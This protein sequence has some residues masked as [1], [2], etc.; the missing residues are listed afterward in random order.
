MESTD[1]IAATGQKLLVIDDEATIRAMLTAYLREQSYTVFTAETGHDGLAMFA[2]ETPALVLVD[3]RLPD[4]DG[5]EVMARIR[6][7]AP[8]TPVIV[9]SASSAIDDAIEALRLGAWEFLSKPI[10]ELSVLEHA[11]SRALERAYLL[12]ENRAYQENLEEL[13]SQRTRELEQATEQLAQHRDHLEELV[14]AR[15]QE[16][17]DSERRFRTL[18]EAA[19]EGVIIHD[20]GT[21]IW[22]NDLACEKSGYSREELL[23]GQA[24]DLLIAPESRQFVGQQ[25]AGD[26]RKPYE[27]MA[28]RKDETVF[29]VEVHSRPMVYQG[30]TVRI[31]AINDI[32]ERKAAERALRESERR[33]DAIINNATAVIC[34]KDITGRYQLV[35]QRFCELFDTTPEEAVG[36]TDHDFFPAQA[37]YAFQMND[38]KVLAKK[39]AIQFQES[40]PGAG[41]VQVYLSIKFPLCDQQGQTYGVCSI[42]SDITE[43]KRT[44][45]MMRTAKQKAEKSARQ[46]DSYAQELEWRNF[47]LQQAQKAAE[48]ASTAKSEFL[49]NMS[50]EIRTPMNGIMGMTA[51]LE[52]TELTPDQRHY[53]ETISESSDTLMEIINNILDFSRIEAG[54]ME[55]NITSFDLRSL[56]EDLGDIM[57]SRAHDQGLEF[58]CNIDSNVPARL[59]GDPGRVRQVLYNLVGNALKFTER[60]EIVVTV[61]LHRETDNACQIRFSVSD[62]GIGIPDVALNQLFDPFTQGD[63]SSTRQ[64]G[65]TGLGLAICKRLCEFMEGEIGARSNA[66]DGSTFWFT[67]V[68]TRGSSHEQPGLDFAESIENSRILVLDGNHSSQQAIVASLVQMGCRAETVPDI[69][70]A[71]EILSTSALG[72]DGFDLAFVDLSTV[73]KEQEEST[74]LRVAA[75]QSPA[76]PLIALATSALRGDA[77]R[78]HEAGYVGFLSKPVRRSLLLDSIAAVLA[79]GEYR[80]PSPPQPLITS[81][82]IAEEKKHQIRILVVDDSPTSRELAQLALD[83][84]GVRADT[85]SDGPAAIDALSVKVYDAVLMD[86]Q[87]PEMNGLEATRRIRDTASPVLDHEVPVIALTAHAMNRDRDQCLEAGMNG[88]VAKP[89]GINELIPVLREVLRTKVPLRTTGGD[90]SGDENPAPQPEMAPTG[91]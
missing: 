7:Q 68:F 78:C 40:I 21:L 56:V 72:G 55:L 44:E 34:L 80:L 1:K 14:V 36:K 89:F 69:P 23:G 9:I 53:V 59:Q 20:R 87:M 4:I 31:A 91:C 67:A 63:T 19:F 79:T 30:R 8:E 24:L 47:E 38:R 50:H 52:E 39:G 54:Q 46:V 82:S 25:M 35:N 86:I 90:R 10:V 88:Y 43:L 16:L 11:I 6:E 51:I 83:R 28:R 66:G 77:A 2:K 49:A 27:V 5:L 85:V 17:T 71:L 76:V 32:T 33:L 75:E 64:F 74:L 73:E 58:I 22:V 15:T 57:A 37:A 60:G 61:T 65:G 42:S 29:P 26:P 18:V 81:Y 62:T 13:V 48:T 70:T 45:E 3:L 41:G 12:R 84:I